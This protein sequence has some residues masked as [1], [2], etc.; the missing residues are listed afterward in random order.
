MISNAMFIARS[1]LTAGQVGMNVAG[2]N[3]ANAATPGYSRQTLGLAPSADQAFGRGRIGR[4]VDILSIRRSADD[5]LSQRLRAAISDD[6]AGSTSRQRL[7][8]LERLVGSL[9][10]S[11]L[12]T[13]LGAFFNA[14]SGLAND[15]SLTAARTGVLEQGR[16]ASEY[17]RTLRRDVVN[18]QRGLDEELRNSAATANGLLGEIARLNVQIVNNGGPNAAALQDRRDQA[19][20]RLAELVDITT[21]TQA[22]GSVDVLIGSTQLVTAG[23][24]RGLRYE[25]ISE[26]G[27]AVPTITTADRG[28][29]LPAV[30]GQLGALLQAR[31]DG[32]GDTLTKL[33]AV[34]SALIYQVNRVYSTG[35]SATPVTSMTSTLALPLADRTLAINDPTNSTTSVAPFPPGS[36]QLVVRVRNDATGS[37]SDV[38]IPIDLDGLRNDGSPGFDQDTTL[39]SLRASLDA[40]PNLDAT[41]TPDGKLKITAANGSSFSFVGDTSGVLTTLGVNTYFQGSGAADIALRADLVGRPDLLNARGVVNG[42]LDDAFIARSV[43]KLRDTQVAALGGVTLGDSW[44][45]TVQQLGVRVSAAGTQADASKAV[46]ENLESQRSAIAGVNLDEEAINLV[47][48][49]TQYQASARFISVIQELTQSLL[50]LV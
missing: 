8:E 25:Q 29:R 31:K 14:W 41:F 7:G 40:L 43:A 27:V 38:A 17:I 20:D 35:I 19:L 30:S 47:L 37:F 46:R 1:G 26:D 48:Y 32:V 9:D 5:A 11:G 15:P 34:A 28:E 13:Q 10:D 44:S 50:Q 21:V 36:G 23:L 3:V 6:A 24:N 39:E 22:S 16:A 18:Q 33:D 42:N 49:Q 45:S 4:G 12:S 2:N